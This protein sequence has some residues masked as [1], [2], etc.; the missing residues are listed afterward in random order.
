MAVCV[1]DNEAVQRPV[2]AEGEQRLVLPAQDDQGDLPETPRQLHQV[3]PGL[4]GLAQ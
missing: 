2:P 4:V 3:R 1:Q